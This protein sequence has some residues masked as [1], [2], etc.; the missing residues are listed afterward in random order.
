MDF[1]FEYL[2]L[3]NQHV[4]DI[5]AYDHILFIL[6]LC[7]GYS[8]LDWKKVVILVT[9]FTIGHSITLALSVLDLVNPN[10]AFIEAL[11]PITIIITALTNILDA[12]STDKSTNKK[13][14]LK[15][16]MALIFGLI[17]GLGF[18]FYLKEILGSEEQIWVPLLGFNIGVELALIIVVIVVLILNFIIEKLLKNNYYLWKIGVSMVSACIAVNLLMN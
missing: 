6:V 5:N 2:K 3:G 11:I 18:S 12:R 9:A 16:L 1:I 15:Y 17:H 7:I 14:S 13:I 4:L 10:T 8:I